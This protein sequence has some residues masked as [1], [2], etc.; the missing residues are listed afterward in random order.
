SVEE[1]GECHLGPAREDVFT[2]EQKERA[3]QALVP[4]LERAVDRLA[5]AGRHGD[6]RR[7]E[8]RVWEHIERLEAGT[9]FEG[10]DQYLPYL[11]P[12]PFT[13][14]DYFPRQPVVVL[15][16]PLRL[17]EAGQE[18]DKATAQ[19]LARL[20]MQG[21]LLPGQGDAYLSTAELDHLLGLR[22]RLIFS[23]LHQRIPGEDP[24]EVVSMD[25]RSV[26]VF[27]GQWPAFMEELNRWRQAGTR[28]VLVG[29]TPE[30]ARAL[31]DRLRDYEVVAPVREP[32]P[33]A[34]E[35]G[36]VLVTQGDVGAGFLLPDTGLAVVAD[37]DVYGRAKK[38]RLP[39]P[40]QGVR[41][42]L[43]QLAP[44]D[45][46]VH[47]SHGVGKYL[48]VRTLEIEGAQ[49]D[50]LFI[51]YAGGD[52]LYV[53]TEQIELI[54]KYVGTEGHQPKLNRLGGT[55]W[56]RVKSRVKE[57]V[58]QMAADL[59]K[60]YA[61]RQ[62]LPGYAFPPDTPW[63]REFEDAFRYEETPDQ[64]QATE[65]IK[66]D[67]EKARPMDRLLCGDV[68]YGKTEVAIRA[69][70]KAVMGGKQVAVLVP[71][72]ILAQQHYHTFR[73]RLAGYPIHV[74]VLSRF[75][76]PQEQEATLRH[77]RQGTVDVLI[78]T[79]RLLQ[80]DVG[81]HD[82]GLLIVDEEHRFGV[83]HK[84]RLKQLR[85]SVDVLTLT[86]TPI[87]RTLH[88]A[89]SGLRDMSVIETPPEDRFPVQTYVVEYSEALIRDAI[90]REL[91]RG[92]QVY[93]VHNRVKTIERAAARVQK[94]APEARV[95]AAHGQMREDLL[96]K[97][98]LD[99]MEG[100]YDI[101]VSTSII[102]SGL[103]IA[104]VN[105]LIVEDAHELGLAQLYQLRG[106]V[107][108]SN[109]LAYAYFT[110]HADRALS[111]TAERR[112]EAIAEFTELGSGFK[113]AMRDLEIRGAGNLLGAEQH[114]F[115]V[116][117]GFDLYCRLLEE[118]VRELQGKPPVEEVPV[119]LELK[120]DAYL[121]DDW[122][123]SSGQKVEAYK[124]I[125]AI[126]GPEDSRLV[127]EELEDRYGPVPVPVLNLLA[128]ARIKAL[129]QELK[130]PSVS[131]QR[132]RVL[133]RLPGELPPGAYGR[134]P[135]RWR[136]RLSYVGGRR[137]A[138]TLHW[139]GAGAPQMLSELETLLEHLAELT[140]S[141]PL[142]PRG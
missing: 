8:E 89:L 44:G 97:V 93:Y 52:A 85:L 119:T 18:A 50:Y 104:N 100:E 37:A 61:A 49:R 60:L 38:R 10:I 9:R 95:A 7:L 14:L 94:L 110:F 111:E 126:R 68:G 78:G 64:R 129:C 43:G 142:Q 71:T 45:F 55:E 12:A 48:G 66:A 83:A 62:A 53:P 75:R 3:R 120:V 91:Q 69:A 114:G 16:E 137:P 122:I 4:E 58:R 117:V 87:P 136:G 70:F 5:R 54:Q 98:M 135:P 107:G 13:L 41:I 39:R 139:H 25:V 11:C 67:M 74:E 34:P 125:G 124:M 76:S 134:M 26:P 29:A 27:H 88:M 86:A 20:L 113:I 127:K 32:L 17:R 99:F 33:R 35:P 112:L 2:R 6:A 101:L 103:D 81:F 118:A 56:A 42:D 23:L 109:R 80:D 40:K 96:E 133:I 82:L 47:E 46:V 31:A 115:I 140:R 73:E 51:Q 121:P 28:V 57:S 138:L 21:L 65:E 72:T 84:E 116:A 123:Q 106:R 1:L 92:G 30:R 77:L 130:I 63:Q 90:G 108:R 24:D 128:V 79:H 22:A 19:Q 132:D 141:V 102:E 15:D 131:Q 105:T 36:E 59:L